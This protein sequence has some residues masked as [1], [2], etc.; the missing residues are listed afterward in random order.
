[1]K[2]IKYLLLF[3]IVFS[4]F[5]KETILV[6]AEDLSYLK[7]DVTTDKQAYTED[8]EITYLLT[9]SNTSA[10]EATDVVVTSTLPDSLVVT[11]KDSIVEVNQVIWN[12]D[13]IAGKSETKLQFTAKIK[14]SVAPPIDTNVVAPQTGDQTNFWG[15]FVLLIFSSMVLAV[16][17]KALAKKKVNKELTAIL[18]LAM[19]LPAFTV[20]NAEVRK[21]T[22]ANTH[23]LV[24]NNKEYVVTTNVEAMID[25]SVQSIKANPS[26]IEMAPGEAKAFTVSAIDGNGGV[27]GAVEVASETTYATSDPAIITVKKENNL[28]NVYAAANA[29]NG[30]SETINIIYR[31]DGKDFKAEITV[32]IV[33]NRAKGTLIGK[34]VDADDTASLVGGVVKIFDGNNLLVSEVITNEDGAYETTLVP[35][36]YRVEV[37]HPDYVTD[38]SFV[39]IN[40]AN[41]TTYDSRLLL[42]GNEYIGTGTVM[43]TIMNAITGDPA[44]NINLAIRQGR[45]NTSGPIIQTVVTDEYGEYEVELLGGNYT[46]EIT[47]PGYIST[48]ANL[49]ALGGLTTYEQNGTISPEGV[50]DDG[51]RVVLSWGGN[52]D[53][54]DSHY[55]GPAAEGG[56]FHVYYGDR[57]FEDTNNEAYLDVDDTSS[58]GPETVTVIKR[59]D[60]GTYTYGVFNYTDYDEENNSNLANSDAIVR[61]YRGN[62][63]I[64]TYNVPSN[65]VGNLWRVFEIRDG[66]IVPVNSIDF[67]TDDDD[68]NNFYPDGPAV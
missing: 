19:L 49:I 5:L 2:T 50:L 14:D 26:S 22:A 16:G 35:G 9:V 48:I 4:F 1:M 39:T 7:I 43:G 21:E 15:Y 27:I 47:A 67:I 63:L 38:T 60:V 46:M 56:R 3:S 51:L 12:V 18:V 40:S 10:L 37:S 34:I 59:V 24:I 66:E 28:A 61:V 44:P 33:D 6:H 31:A 53:D 30:E 13:S 45:N 25:F 54:L 42:V 55:T 58:Y 20:A 57:E 11:S 23:K 17:I 29:Q 64:A 52:P 32:K 62:V 8:D 68:V 41:T 36:T 65:K